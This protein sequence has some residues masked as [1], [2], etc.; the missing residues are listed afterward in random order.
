MECCD[1]FA[2]GE[3]AVCELAAALG[4]SETAARAYV[5][6]AVE[7]RDRLLR[8]W[9]RVMGGEVPAWKGRQIAS[10]TIPLLPEAAASVDAQVAP[11]VDQ[12][13]FGRIMRAVGAAELRFDPDAA[14]ERVRKS[15]EKRGV[16][17][18]DHL[19]GTSEVRAVTGTRTRWRSTPR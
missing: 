6:Q 3:F 7:L 11:F 4:M 8:L 16:W 13:S 15:A 18:E 9:G 2:V 5:G 19:D 17:V 10:E 14:A 1:G 12:L